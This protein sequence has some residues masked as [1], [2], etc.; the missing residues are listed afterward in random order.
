MVFQGNF[1][2]LAAKMRAAARSS[3]RPGISTTTSRPAAAAVSRTGT[4]SSRSSSGSKPRMPSSLTPS[5]R[6]GSSTSGTSPSAVDL[7]SIRSNSKEILDVYLKGAVR[8]TTKKSYDYYWKRYKKFCSQTEL[9]ISKAESIG[10]FLVHL[11]ESSKGNSSSLIAK[12]AI[13]FHLKLMSPFKKAATDNYFISRISKSIKKKFKRPVKKA[14]RFTSELTTKLILQLLSSGSFKDERTAI[15]VLM[16]FCFFARYE[17]VAKLTKDCVHVIPPGHVMIT[18]PSAKNYE[19]WD[20]QTSWVSGNEGGAVDPVK[21]IKDYMTKLS[22]NIKWLFPN[23]RRGRK[24]T[25]SF[26]DS[27]VSYDNMLKLLREGLERIGVK[28]KEYSLHGLRT[29]A[30]SEAANS[31]KKVDKKDLK[32]HG[33]WKSDGMVDHY[34]QLSL[35][36]KLAPSRSLGLYDS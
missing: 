23:F 10:L 22:G 18:F 33:R 27:P 6:S 36:K 5:A 20:A 28:G 34:H 3:A 8:E 7:P 25:I 16:Q 11:A 19:N 26:I 32:R 15:F 35:D 14:K 29:G 21:L 2:Q 13:K 12:H 9:L 1:A 30:T 24:N 4:G 31:S 17:E